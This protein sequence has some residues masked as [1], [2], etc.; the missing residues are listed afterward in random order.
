[1]HDAQGVPDNID[2]VTV[3]LPGGG[4]ATL[5]YDGDIPG[6]N[7]TSG[8]YT[9]FGEPLPADGSYAYTFHVTDVDGHSAQHT[10]TFN[11]AL[12]PPVN[13]DS[14]SALYDASGRAIDFSWEPVDGAAFYRV[15][16]Y[17]NTPSLYNRLYAFATTTNSYRMP[18][19]FLK[20]GVVHRYRIT[21]H[22]E[23]FDENVDNVSSSHSPFSTEMPGLLVGPVTPGDV[24][25]DGLV[26]LTDALQLL[27]LMIDLTPSDGVYAA[28]DTDGDGKLSM[29]DLIYILQNVGG[30]RPNE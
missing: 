19:G 11:A 18:E 23:F 1:V 9:L 27:S 2:S 10:E 5:A 17:P 28:A 6:G 12:L 22:R 29:P 4:Q 3:D 13:P 14:L 20:P 15:E 7:S 24:N 30:M 8:F 16:I 21:A 25:A 26:D